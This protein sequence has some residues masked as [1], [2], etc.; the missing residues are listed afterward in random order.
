MLSFCFIYLKLE[1]LFPTLDLFYN[2]LESIFHTLPIVSVENQ[3]Q[4]GDILDLGEHMVMAHF[5]D[6][7]TKNLDLLITCM[8]TDADCDSRF[9]QAAESSYLWPLIGTII[10]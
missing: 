7:V 8:V 10:T 4:V 5:L 9:I 3:L 1:P 2:S 6:T